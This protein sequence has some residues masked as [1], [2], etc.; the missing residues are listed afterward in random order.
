MADGYQDLTI[1]ISYSAPESESAAENYPASANLLTKT[2]EGFALSNPNLKIGD[3]AYFCIFM[4]P[5]L[6]VVEII[7]TDSKV[8]AS[9][10]GTQIFEQKNKT[11]TF[12]KTQYDDANDDNT[13][14]LP[15]VANLGFNPSSNITWVGGK[16][17]NGVS[18][19]EDY[20]TLVTKE[21]GFVAARTTYSTQGVIYKLDAISN[22]SILYEVQSNGKSVPKGQLEVAIIIG[23]NT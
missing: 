8:S 23:T 12:K 1:S 21:V 13:A 14:S 22:E 9:K 7:T 6:K 18:V 10:V 17:L 5:A 2:T 4:H 15:V 3:E 19:Q 20:K 16:Q 11:F